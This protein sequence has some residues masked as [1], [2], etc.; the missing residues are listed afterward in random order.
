MYFKFSG[1]RNSKTG[2]HD[3]YCRLVESYRN[4]EGRICHRTIL[5]I[6]FL[7]EAISPEQLNAISR[8]LTDRYQQ[9]IALFEDNDEV[10]LRWSNQLWERIVKENR[11]DL[12]E[13][14][15]TNRKIDADTM[16][17]SNVRE[18]GAEWMA[19]NTWKALQL[20]EVLAAQ[21]FSDKEIKLAQTQ[22]ISRAV[23]PASELATSRWIQENSAICELTG[24]AEESINK[25]CLYR[26]ALKLYSIKDVLEQHLTVRTNELFD[27][28]DKILLYDLTNTY[29]EGDKRN[30]KLAKF[31]RSKEKR[32]D[33]RLVVLA[34]VVNVYGFVKYSSIHEGNFADSSDISSII[35]NLRIVTGGAQPALVVIDAGI[36]S[37]D[38]LQT[39]RSKGYHYLCVSRKQL[40]NYKYDSNR[41]AVLHTT[42]TGNDITLRAIEKEDMVDYCLEVNSPAKALKEK[43]MK[44][45]FELNFEEGL[46][47]IQASILKKGGVKTVAKVNERLGRLKQKYPSVHKRYQIDLK[48]DESGKKILQIDWQKD[49]LAEQQKQESLG[50][51]FLRTSLD[52]KEEALVWETYNTIREVESTFRTLKTD[53]DLRPIYHK[54]DKST[55]A[56]LHLGILAYSLVN[57]IRC[58]LKRQ[59]IH[60]GWQE[61]VRIGNTQKVITTT[62]YNAA[63]CEVVVRKCSEPT[64]KLKQLQAALHIKAKPF[65]KIS[66]EK[67][68]VH[69]PPNHHGTTPA[70]KGFSS[71]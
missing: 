63:Q 20:D 11:L 59:N 5:H 66:Q 40:K 32:N 23:H 15:P 22:V 46:A 42:R 4:L 45:R 19:F 30:S 53:L 35:N 37:E 33:A 27:I 65:R 47:K 31:G 71:A 13:Y 56:H 50:R 38:N 48:S 49:P 1:R 28:Q 39:I 60:H 24:F 14:A 61:I 64:E 68:V 6:G 25:D 2:E 67:S 70:Y 52:L 26:S 34:M 51:Y 55:V 36:A 8:K 29:F 9:K 58:Q 44:C 54:N 62:G 41:E 3:S 12:S 21:G 43:G 17:H 7:E 57:T 69:K 16:K 10:V 18:V